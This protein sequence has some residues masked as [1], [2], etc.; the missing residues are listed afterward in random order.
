MLKVNFYKNKR[1]G[2]KNYGKIYARAENH[3]P[4][5]LEGLALHIAEHGSIYTYDVILGVLRKV[6]TCVRELAVSGQPVKLDGLCI[7][8]ASVRS[9]PA[10]DV[11]TF[12]LDSNVRGVRLQFRPTG[13]SSNAKVTEVTQ[14]GYSSLANRIKNGE[15]VLSDVK[16]EYIAGGSGNEPVVNP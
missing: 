13:L 16:G 4:I 14:L 15:I 1:Q 5:D 3:E 8:K 10:N 9:K 11:D 2:D 12:G 7:V 6:A